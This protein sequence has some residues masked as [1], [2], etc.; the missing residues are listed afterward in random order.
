MKLRASTSASIVE[1]KDDTPAF[2]E[3]RDVPHGA[4]E[5]NWEKSKA[6]SGE[7]RAIWVYTPP[8]YEKG[9]K[10]YPVL[11]LFHGS[12]DTAAGW[13]MAGNA[14]FVFDNLLAEK[15]M[16]PMVVAMPFGHAHPSAH[17]PRVA[18][19]MTRC[20]RSTC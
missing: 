14:N 20:S 10:R 15:K 6:I 18:S 7:T 3:A 4:V 1:V 5:I 19:P 16:L 11:Y 17:R 8:G 2:W 13:T 12:N 9:T